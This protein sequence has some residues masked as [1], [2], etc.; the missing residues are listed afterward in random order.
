MRSVLIAL[1]LILFP[2]LTACG[3]EPSTLTVRREFDKL[4]ADMSAGEWY[5]EIIDATL[6]NHG[7]AVAYAERDGKSIAKDANG[8]I[9]YEFFDGTFDMPYHRLSMTANG[10]CGDTPETCK[11]FSRG[12]LTLLYRL[13]DQFVTGRTDF[14]G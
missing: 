3:S 13:G 1:V 7:V 11:F 10:L 5:F 12:E 14:R 6:V 4:L 8:V 9:H 2:S